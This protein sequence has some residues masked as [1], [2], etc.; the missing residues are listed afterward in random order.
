M[1]RPQV[2]VDTNY[3]HLPQVDIAVRNISQ[4]A[5][6]DIRFKFSAPV[7][8][9]DGSVISDLTH[10]K[11]GLDFLAPGEHVICYW[12]RLE[13]LLPLLRDKSLEKGSQ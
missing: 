6:R 5:A 8:S 11:E 10:F 9:S 13:N 3:G 4:G 1:G 7:E 2:I 12:D